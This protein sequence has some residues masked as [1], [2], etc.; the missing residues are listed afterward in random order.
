MSAKSQISVEFLVIMIAALFIF[1]ILLQVYSSR[2]E[3]V[4]LMREHTVAE[5]FVQRISWAINNV[6]LGGE[7]TKTK[8]T[9]P[10]KIRG[11]IDYNISLYESVL[12]IEWENGFKSYPLLTSNVNLTE[13]NKTTYSIISKNN[14]IYVQ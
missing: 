14:T 1:V 9:I 6:Y 10:T 7:G 4:R 13:F 11:R 12:Y 3:E 2:A 8:I 5:H